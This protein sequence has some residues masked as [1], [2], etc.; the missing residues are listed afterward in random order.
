MTTAAAAAANAVCTL[1][2]HSHERRVRCS[3]WS[4]GPSPCRLIASCSLAAE[5]G[6]DCVRA[7]W[8]NSYSNASIAT[9][10]SVCT[11]YLVPHTA[12]VPGSTQVDF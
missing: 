4:L 10:A 6:G 11:W 9:R 7:S 2:I 1:V 3:S 12:A 5:T 8:L